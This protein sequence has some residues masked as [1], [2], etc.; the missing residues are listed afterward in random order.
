[1][2]FPNKAE[3]YPSVALNFDLPML[4]N[5]KILFQ[6][7]RTRTNTPSYLA[8]TSLTR[9]KS[10]SAFKVTKLFF[11]QLQRGDIGLSVLSLA[12]QPTDCK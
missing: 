8:S 6:P 9:K 4:P 10:F 5:K 7:E 2:I 12:S 3:A 11:H 1:M